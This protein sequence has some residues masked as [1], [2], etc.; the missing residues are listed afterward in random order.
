MRRF[1]LLGVVAGVLSATAWAQ[2][3]STEQ[4]PPLPLKPIAMPADREADSYA[5]YSQLL[6]HGLIE[7]A[8]AERTVWLVE[9]T[10]TTSVRSDEPCDP[11][12][13]EGGGGISMSP[14]RAI[15]VPP[16]REL[17]WR[18]LLADFD[19]HCHERLALSADRLQPGLPVHLM[20]EAAM[21]RY[22]STRMGV[23]QEQASQLNAHEFDGAAGMH[24]F[25][26]V[27][28]T[29]D[30][31]LALVHTGMWCGGLCGMW[32]WVV[33]EHVDGKWKPLPWVHSF[34]IS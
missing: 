22:R 17:E 26:E 29:P 2:Q 27:Y 24:S 3:R 18:A 33:L 34:T 19:A 25:S 7:W 5:I 23:T 9:D 1:A 6:P 31:R 4:P 10:T 11:A 13:G 20:D 14:N 12:P 30:H 8:D 15:Q 32:A 21:A 28:F 16:E